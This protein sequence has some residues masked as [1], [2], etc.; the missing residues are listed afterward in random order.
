MED[1]PK[2]MFVVEG[3][4]QALAED[5]GHQAVAVEDL[6]SSLDVAVVTWDV[7]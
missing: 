5:E 4:Y 3:K 2:A 7:C 1:G 6:C